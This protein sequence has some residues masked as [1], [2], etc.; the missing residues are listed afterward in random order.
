MG[1]FVGGQ[2]SWEGRQQQTQVERLKEPSSTEKKLE[3]RLVE[4]WLRVQK[5]A[6]EQVPEFRRSHRLPGSDEF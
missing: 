4:Q 5:E 1:H 2:T 3:C 6:P